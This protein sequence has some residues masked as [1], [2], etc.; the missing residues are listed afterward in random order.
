MSNDEKAKVLGSVLEIDEYDLEK[1]WTKQ[2]KLFFRWA[3]E[4]AAARLAVDEAKAAL[5]IVRAEIDS[6]VRS[7][8][9]GHGIDGKVTEKMVE[10]VVVQSAVCILAVRKSQKAKHRYDIVS[11]L[12][13]ALEQRK[14]ALEYLVRLRLSDYFSEPRAPKEHREELEEMQKDRAFRPRRREKDG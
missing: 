3:G 14:S 10:A 12:V 2:P 6:E 7:D 9:E 4:A 8:P 13:S 5:E 11:A 1:E